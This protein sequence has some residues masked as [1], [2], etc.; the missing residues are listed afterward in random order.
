MLRFALGA[1]ITW[2]VI[3][4]SPV[5]TAARQ[6]GE[7]A[8]AVR[9]NQQV[10]LN[11]D[12][13]LEVA[14]LARRL[15]DRDAELELLRGATR[16]GRFSEVARIELA[17]AL[18]TEHP[19][20]AVALVVPTLHDEGSAQLF[21]AARS[22][23]YRAAALGIEAASVTSLNKTLP[24]LSRR[25][26]RMIGAAVADA[27]TAAGR[28]QMQDVLKRYPGDLVALDVA[29]KL[30]A[31][32]ELTDRERWLVARCLYRHALYD[33][34][35]DDLA[36]LV[37]C[38]T[39]GVPR[40]EVRFL[41]G[42]CDFRRDRYAKADQWYRAALEVAPGSE[43]KADLLVHRARA[44]ELMG[45]PEK[46]A[47]LVVQAIL[48]D[49]SDNRRLYLARLRLSTDRLDLAELGI[50]RI[51]SAAD[52]DRGR[53]LIG[54]YHIANRKPAAAM[55]KLHEIHHRP[56]RG[57]ARVL[58]AGLHVEAGEVAAGLQAL[59]KAAPE[60]DVFWACHARRI[61]SCIDPEMRALWQREQ[62]VQASKD[63]TRL[64]WRALRELA[65]LASDP[66][67]LDE[68]RRR[69]A[70]L[71]PIETTG[72]R[73]ELRG[74]AKELVSAGLDELAVRWDPDGFPRATPAEVL[75][76]AAFF[77][78]HGA[79]WRSIRL[80]DAA[81]RMLGA[82]LPVRA[83]PDELTEALYPVSFLPQAQA[84]STLAGVDWKVVSG[85]AREESRWDAG[86]LSRVGARGLMQLMPQTAEQV[87]ARLGDAPPTADGLFDPAVSLRL[88]AAELAR[89]VSAFGG[90]VPAAVAAY[91]AGEAQSR[92][93]LEQ[94]GPDCDEAR[95]LLTISFAA[96]RRY[97][98]DVLASAVVHGAMQ[99]DP[100]PPSAP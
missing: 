48:T 29:R 55:A 46:A 85:V 89:L 72:E 2:L 79:P 71:R 87:S 50:S 26:R 76:S 90:F 13:A 94:C 33:E 36:G 19:D 56:W 83:Y 22:V 14:L 58:L 16:G 49:A 78:E 32:A 7:V 35:A 8:A 18:V 93:W 86:V 41:L 74:L 24:D 9:R 81:W 4:P 68:V 52:R 10:P 67:L 1:A 28:Q 73:E 95:F 3:T 70:E 61:M 57:P 62:L 63:E 69:V 39:K 66:E 12:R 84:A 51:R 98:A 53:I 44:L 45:Q 59:S 20:Q 75:W 30:D 23:V 15:G 91:N 77:R 88:G 5:H 96:T 25:S 99:P 82:D 31:A 21:F 17:Q 54:L 37:D 27:G 43:E 42:R 92:L 34:A 64:S 80:A 40:W 97:T 100:E 65:V 6:D 11:P 60:L 38:K 47:E